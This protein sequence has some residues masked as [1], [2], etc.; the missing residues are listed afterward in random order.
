M[1]KKLERQIAKEAKA[2]TRRE[3]IVRAIEGKLTWI[4]A[5]E[6][7]RISARQMRRLKRLYERQ[8]YRG[9]VDQRGKPRAKR[10]SAAVIA[11]V[12]RLKRE[13]YPDFSIQHF[14]EQ[15]TEKHKLAVSYT[16]TRLL[17]QTAGLVEKAP[18]RGKYRRRRE[19]RPMTGMLLPR[20]LDTP[21]DRGSA[22]GGSGGCP[23]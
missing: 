18:A 10:V 13:V 5:S 20:R 4:Q 23:R 9:I 21:M 8:G 1:V 12:C 22:D 19:R 11:E 3:V 16:W 7:L 6:I 14:Y 17:L 15:A 2:M